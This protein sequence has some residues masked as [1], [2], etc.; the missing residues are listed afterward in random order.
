MALEIDAI[1]WRSVIHGYVF[2]DIRRLSIPAFIVI[3]L[4]VT[5]LL[6]SFLVHVL[7]VES[8]VLDFTFFAISMIWL[9][10]LLSTPLIFVVNLILVIITMN[11]VETYSGKAKWVVL[12]FCYLQIVCLIFVSI[13]I[14][15][16]FFQFPDFLE[17]SN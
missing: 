1:T 6:F 3:C 5:V 12:S 2:R 16:T 9:I 11:L 10:Y 7:G 14:F 15:A 4:H 8:E 13:E 17:W